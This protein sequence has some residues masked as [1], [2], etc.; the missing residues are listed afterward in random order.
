MS[1]QIYPT[2]SDMSVLVKSLDGPHQ[3]RWGG[4]GWNTAGLTNLSMDASTWT[5]SHG[6]S[7][8]THWPWHLSSSNHF[9]LVMWRFI[10][11]TA[12]GKQFKQVYLTVSSQGLPIFSFTLDENQASRWAFKTPYWGV[13]RD[14]ETHGPVDVCK[15]SQNNRLKQPGAEFT[16]DKFPSFT[17]THVSRVI[18]VINALFLGL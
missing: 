17:L 18:Q 6:E 8:L 15:F 11:P 7:N 5:W 14:Q 4:A 9:W 1:S 10:W 2:L 13:H 16:E 3:E 12:L